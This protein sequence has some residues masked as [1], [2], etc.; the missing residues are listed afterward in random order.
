MS[1][2]FIALG[3]FVLFALFVTLFMVIAWILGIG[4]WKP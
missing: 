3:C 2:I 1:G 4:E